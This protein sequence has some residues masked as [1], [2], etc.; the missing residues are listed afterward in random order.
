MDVFVL[1]REFVKRLFRGAVRSCGDGGDPV[2]IGA[3]MGV[4]VGV[5]VG[6]LRVFMVKISA[7]L[8]RKG[9]EGEEWGRLERKTQQTH[10]CFCGLKQKQK[11][12]KESTI[13][14]IHTQKG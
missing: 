10:W 7:R 11:T 5:G 14:S 9:F 13:L 3:D 6:G 2:L 8:Q 1:Q 12:V 4:G